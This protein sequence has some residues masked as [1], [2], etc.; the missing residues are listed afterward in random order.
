MPSR[1]L[2]LAALAA[3]GALLAPAAAA[4]DSIVYADQGDIWSMRPDGS[5]KVRLTDG[6]S[7][8]SPTQA[9]DGTIAAVRGAGPITVMARDGRVL[10][11]ITTAPA[12]SSNGGGFSGTPVDLSFSP[13]GS[14]IAYAYVGTSCPVAS[15]CGGVQRSTFYTRA[16]VT[17]ATPHD[18]WGNQFGVSDPEW[19]TN[20]R[21]LV[22]GG[23][24]SQV[25]IDDLGGGDYSFVPWLRPNADQGDG[26]LSRDG[27]RLATTMFYGQDL[28]LAF[29]AVTG[30][31]TQGPPPTATPACSAS[32]P[33]ERF[34]D[35]SW[36]PDSAGLA[37][38]SRDGLEVL[39]FAKL[40]ATGCALTGPSVVL[41]P[42]GSEPDWGPADP[43]AARFSAGPAAPAPAPAPR[44]ATQP[45]GP[46]GPGAGTG[47]GPGAGTLAVVAGGAARQT[48]RGTLTIRC[49]APVRAT[50]AATATVRAGGR[51]HRT[52]GSAAV[53]AGRATTLRMRFSRASTKAIRAALRREALR[54]TVTL[55]ATASGGARGT[56]TRSVRL[57]R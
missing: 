23:S 46:A 19:I 14:K 16:D 36:A 37:F 38:E 21:A 17:Q 12:R 52:K 55:V 44:P 8:H 5:G 18:V 43:P 9:D 7:W 45:G 30:D 20:D 25:S 24:G 26:E 51:V 4:A 28:T 47:G 35:P 1:T 27:R 31:A 10:R 41:A 48:F 57:A 50:C 2:L 22:F 53:A 54:A 15:S 3:A 34:A 49:T 40:D 42:T 11:T 56:A 39:R 6:G 29:F 33:D 32:S 13:D